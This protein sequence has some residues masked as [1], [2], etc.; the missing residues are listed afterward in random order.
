MRPEINEAEAETEVGE[1]KDENEAEELLWGRNQ[2][3]C[4]ASGQSIMDWVFEKL[5]C[6]NMVKHIHHE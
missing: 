6:T 4:E 5:F 2:Q 1:S 3:P